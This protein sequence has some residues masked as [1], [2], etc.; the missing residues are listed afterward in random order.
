MCEL[1][2][3][4]T[5][6]TEISMAIAFVMGLLLEYFPKLRNLRAYQ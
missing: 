5:E 4:A 6:Q 2:I 3:K 1:L